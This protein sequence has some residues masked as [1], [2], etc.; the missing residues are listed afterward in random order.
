MQFPKQPPVIVKPFI[1]APLLV[2]VMS[3][4]L[5]TSLPLAA[6]TAESAAAEPAIEA[7]AAVEPAVE[8]EKKFSEGMYDTRI[9]GS[10]LESFNASLAEIEKKVTPAE[11]KSVKSGVEWLLMYDLGAKRDR[12]KLAKNLDGLTGA[13]L[14]DRIEAHKRG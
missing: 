3:L 5:L 10:S 11:F 1:A 8:P 14:M 7:A 2:S 12:A 9:D 4:G 13:E 6:N